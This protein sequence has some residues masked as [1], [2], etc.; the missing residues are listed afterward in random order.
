[1]VSDENVIPRTPLLLGWAGVIPFALLSLA[2]VLNLN[3][4]WIEP[5]RALI[6]YGACILSFM[7][8]VQWGLA[9]HSPGS[10]GSSLRYVASVTPALLAWGSLALPSVVA[11]LTLAISFAS[12]FAF[13]A[14]IVRMGYAPAWY[15][16][17]RRQ[18]TVPVIAC[19]FV[20]LF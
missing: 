8:G 2:A 13:D 10:E 17:Y 19:L 5:R 18:L 3:L 14:Y 15:S 9:M 11:I 6:G 16:P 20:A 12:L 4:S 1:M 7:G